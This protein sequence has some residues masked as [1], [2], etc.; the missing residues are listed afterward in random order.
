MA[1]FLDAIQAERGDADWQRLAGFMRDVHDGTRQI[2]VA[3]HDENIV[4]MITIRWQSDYAGFRKTPTTP[5]IID[6]YV[7]QAFRRQG[8]ATQLIQHV[9]QDLRQQNFKRVGLS[10]GLLPA[11]TAAWNLYFKHGYQ[12][13]DTGA[14]WQGHNVTPMSVIDFKV[15]QPMLMMSK[16][17]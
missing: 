12:F 2:W 13:D 14:W 16:N 6:L 17:L 15:A 8:L 11:D 7:W 4:G 10:V 1:D 3:R 9:E 5:E